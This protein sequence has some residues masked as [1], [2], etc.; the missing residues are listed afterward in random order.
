MKKLMESCLLVTFILLCMMAVSVFLGGCGDPRHNSPM[1]SQLTAETKKPSLGET[2]NLTSREP[3]EEI[4]KRVF[5]KYKDNPEMIEAGIYAEFHGITIEQAQERF[6][7]SSQFGGVESLLESKAPDTFAGFWIQHTP[8]F[9][10]V[11]AFTSGGEDI[12][13]E[14]IPE[15]LSQY[16]EVRKVE[17]SMEDLWQA[18]NQVETFLRSKNIPFDSAIHPMDNRVDIRVRDRTE[19]DEAVKNGSLVIPDS[20]HVEA[21]PLAILE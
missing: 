17:Y 13:Q 3:I 12:V 11:A 19:I 14:C 15:N 20:V 5:E 18:R 21:G 10:M 2:S 1:A 7:I 9:T 4:Q 8:Y 16:V 6:R